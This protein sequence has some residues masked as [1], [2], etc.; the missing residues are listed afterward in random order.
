MEITG[1]RERPPGCAGV[2]LPKVDLNFIFKKIPIPSR[3]M[4]R[5]S[6]ENILAIFCYSPQKGSAKAGLPPGDH[7]SQPTMFLVLLQK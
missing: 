6:K 2:S 3:N 1:L 5:A 7:S 4:V